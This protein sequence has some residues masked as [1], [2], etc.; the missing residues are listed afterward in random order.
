MP[1][2]DN[3]STPASLH[4]RKRLNPAM[5]AVIR[6]AAWSVLIVALTYLAMHMFPVSI[7]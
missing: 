4:Q 3:A 5:K 1:P 6:A 2:K 7:G